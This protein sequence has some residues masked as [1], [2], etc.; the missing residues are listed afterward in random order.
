MCIYVGISD[1]NIFQTSKN[2]H[3]DPYSTTDVLDGSRSVQ[4]LLQ[5]RSIQKY[6]PAHYDD[7]SKISFGHTKIMLLCIATYQMHKVMLILFI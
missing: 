5:R 7:D 4:N 1:V 2:A 3:F 6:V